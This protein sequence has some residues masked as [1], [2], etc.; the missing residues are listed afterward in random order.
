[1]W[2]FSQEYFGSFPFLI[3]PFIHFILRRLQQW[4][5]QSS[6]GVDGFIANSQNIQGKIRNFYGRDAEVIYPPLDAQFYHPV[7]ERRDYYLM[8]SA[9]VPYKK[10]DPVIEAFNGLDR[11]LLIIGSGPSEAFYRKLRQSNQIFFLGPVER[12][13]LRRFYAEAK[14]LIFPTDEDFGIVPL[15]AQACGTPV[16]A[17][18]KGGALESVK[19]GIFFQKQ[20]PETIRTAVFE[21]EQ[22]HFDRDQT[23]AQVACFDKMAFQEKFQALIRALISKQKIVTVQPV[24]A[25]GPKQ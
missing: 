20:T 22:M 16:I 9:F 5:R 8:V 18:G 13:E 15:E 1:V 10:L 6:A 12:T 11:K 19:T 4:D 17:F 3:R 23:A 24:I 7:G 14:A 25:S 21:F 2:G